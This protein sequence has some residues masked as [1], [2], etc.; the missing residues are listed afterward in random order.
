MSKAPVLRNNTLDG[1]V[2][3]KENHYSCIESIKWPIKHN[4][5]YTL[6]F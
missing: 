4:L 1:F 3:L 6:N 5:D 2:A